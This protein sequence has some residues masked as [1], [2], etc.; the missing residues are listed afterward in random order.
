MAKVK[1]GVLA[2]ASGKAGGV[3]YSRNRGGAYIKNWVKVINPNTPAQSLTRQR[4]STLSSKW[5]ILTTAERQS[6]NSATPNFPVIDRL[7]DSI[8]LSGQQLYM[9]MNRNL[10]SIS[11]LAINVAPAPKTVTSP[12]FVS[13]TVDTTQFSIDYEPNPL[14]TNETL[15][16]D[17]STTKSAGVNYLGRSAFKQISVVAAGTVSPADIFARYNAVFGAGTLQVGAKVFLRMRIVD[18][19]TGIASD[20]IQDSFIVA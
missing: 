16:I 1:L 6:W 15:I 13:V 20:T 12:T 19:L 11:A 14:G 17:A 10:Q 7:G 4:F 5:K 9:Q 3:I 2:A 8:E 18:D